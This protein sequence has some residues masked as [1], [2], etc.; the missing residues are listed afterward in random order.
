[1]E[2]LKKNGMIPVIILAAAVLI[3]MCLSGCSQSGLEERISKLEQTN[4]TYKKQI[5]RLDAVH[6][7]QNLMGRYVWE[8][9][10]QKDPE[11]IDTM[12]AKN[13]PDVS[14]EVAHMGLYRGR[15]AV[16]E[17]LNQHGP[18]GDTIAPGT[19][20]VHTLTTPVIEIA[21]DGQTAKG[22]WKSPGAETISDPVTG[23]LTGMWAWT[24]Y[25]CDFIR[26]DGKWKILHYH[27]YRIFMTP[28]DMNYTDEYESRFMTNAS[29]IAPAGGRAGQES[30]LKEP[31][32]YDNPF[33]ANYVPELVPAPP[34]PYRTFSETFSYGKPATEDKGM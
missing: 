27:V 8:H 11:F 19:L 1:M 20:F 24:K 22:V 29:A 28:A 10:V 34:E 31:T 18:K 23:K 13:N 25:A 2:N 7:I 21:E 6:E 30:S 17:I 4:E 15:D 26:E 14:W 33:T 16:R 12:F 5:E 9:E 3:F 32:T